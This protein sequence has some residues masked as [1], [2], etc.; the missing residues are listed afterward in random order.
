MEKLDVAPLHKIPT[1]STSLV[2]G[3]PLVLTTTRTSW[4]NSRAANRP[5]HLGWLENKDFDLA[6][7]DAATHPA[8][9]RDQLPTQR[10]KRQHR[11]PL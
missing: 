8:N 2:A 11:L 4:S 5:D 7:A 6:G 1:G 10:K 9:H 3:T